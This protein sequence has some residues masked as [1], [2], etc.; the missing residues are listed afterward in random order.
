MFE[1]VKSEFRFLR[2]AVA[3]LKMTTHIAKNPNRVFPWVVE[4]LAKKCGAN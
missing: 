4:E 3:T 2:G 1:R